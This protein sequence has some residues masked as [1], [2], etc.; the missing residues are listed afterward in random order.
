MRK[1]GGGEGRFLVQNLLKTPVACC[2][3]L[4]RQEKVSH[5]GDVLSGIWECRGREQEYRIHS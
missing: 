5:W 2:V 4:N 1:M 3:D